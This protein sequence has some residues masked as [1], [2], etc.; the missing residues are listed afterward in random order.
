MCDDDRSMPLSPRLSRPLAAG[1]TPLAVACAAWGLS[2]LA[3]LASPLLVALLAGTAVSNSRLRHVATTPTTA[4]AAR[5][6]LRLGIVMLGLR[7]VVGDVLALGPRAIALVL[8]TVLVTF[9]VTRLIGH[10]LGLDHDLVVL[11]AAGFSICGAAAIAA[12]QDSVK[13]RRQHVALALALVTLF[14]TAMIAV[15]PLVSRLLGLR[16]A[17]AALWAGASIHE[18]A[19]VAAAAAFIGGAA[20]LALA[21]TIKLGR[22]MMLMPVA[23]WVARS[24]RSGAEV[25]ARVPWFLWA[26]LAAVALRATGLLSAVAL[27]VASGIAT[28]LLCGGM[29]GLGLDVVVRDLWPIQGRVL[30]LASIATATVTLT[31]LAIICLT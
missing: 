31:P 22:V 7:L 18:I 16:P 21:M 26:F 20:P 25:R 14:G 11:V 23:H 4:E 13:A 28:N 8:V 6:M 29:F 24:S 10:R 3:P 17:E 19:Q 2:I 27:D 9:S 1:A 15:I 12:V 5:L 30:A